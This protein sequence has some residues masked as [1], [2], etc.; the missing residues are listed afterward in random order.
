MNLIDALKVNGRARRPQW[1]ESI[2][3]E[4]RHQALT[5][6]RGNGFELLPMDY[7]AEDW[8]RL[9]LPCKHEPEQFTFITGTVGKDGKVWNTDAIH[10]LEQARKI[11]CQHCG[12]QLK[13]TAWEAL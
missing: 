7:L 5:D 8:E 13:A 11:K 10:M 9:E 4:Y 3:I 12:I 1:S 6:H 2:W